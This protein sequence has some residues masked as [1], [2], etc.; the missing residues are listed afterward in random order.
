MVEILIACQ[1]ITQGQASE[2]LKQLYE[3][4]KLLLCEC[5]IEIS[6]FEK[7]EF[8]LDEIPDNIEKILLML[9]LKIFT[10]SSDE[11]YG[12]VVQMVENT[13]LNT[14]QMAVD[15]LVSRNKLVE[16]C[17]CLCLISEKHKSYEILIKWFKILFALETVHGLDC[18]LDYLSPKKVLNLLFL[19][20]PNEDEYKK[21][22]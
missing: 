21:L 6:K 12:I 15:M 1:E 10:D 17:K 9:K 13:N 7:A 16:A 19:L 20:K 3:Q 5:L 2:P 18:S 11:I 4:T 14:L 8:L 22:L